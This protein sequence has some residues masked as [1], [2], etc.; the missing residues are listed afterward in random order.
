MGKE[1]DYHGRRAMFF[2]NRDG[3][4]SQLSTQLLAL[5]NMIY[6][7]LSDQLNLIPYTDST[8]K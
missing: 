4:Y 1:I 2:L 5:Y 8:D 7:D 6:D 3:F